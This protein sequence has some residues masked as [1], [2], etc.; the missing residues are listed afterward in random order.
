MHRRL[1][2]YIEH[3][4]LFTQEDHVLLAVSGGVD[5][6]VLAHLLHKAKYD[7][8]ELDSVEERKNLEISFADSNK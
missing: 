5:S 8:F 7:F 2:D 4:K 1:S 6:T 3:Y